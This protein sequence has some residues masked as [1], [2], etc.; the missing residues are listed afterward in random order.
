MFS[1]DATIVIL[2]LVSLILIGFIAIYGINR[3]LG[4][5]DPDKTERKRK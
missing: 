2:T 5:N 3:Y 4:P 1:Q